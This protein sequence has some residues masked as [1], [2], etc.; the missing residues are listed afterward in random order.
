MSS[1]KEYLLSSELLGNTN[2]VIFGYSPNDFYYNVVN[3]KTQSKTQYDLADETCKNVLK[4]KVDCGPN[5]FDV[6]KEK[7]VQTEL[8]MNKQVANELTE[9]QKQY[10]GADEKFN[11]TNIENDYIIYNIV[12]L[13]IG[14]AAMVGFVVFFND[15]A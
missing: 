14:I 15:R 6:N 4:A 1:S 5:Q 8:C 7:C 13:G 2:K 9:L 10:N 11:D 12:N 3:D